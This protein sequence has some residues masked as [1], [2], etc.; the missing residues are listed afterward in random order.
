M[1][2]TGIRESFE[3]FEMLRDSACMIDHFTDYINHCQDP[4]LRQLLEGQQRIM[5]DQYQQKI[6]VIQSH[7]LDLSN[8]PRFQSTVHGQS[9]SYSSGMPGMHG[10]SIG[11]MY[12]GTSFQYGMQQQGSMMQPNQHSQNMQ[13]QYQHKAYRG[14]S[15]Q[16]ISQGALLFHKCGASMATK[17]ALECAEPHLRELAAK[18]ARTCMDMAYEI[19]KYMEQKGYYQLPNIPSNYVSHMHGVQAQVNQ[20]MYHQGFSGGQN[21]QGH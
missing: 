21:T 2:K 20:G 13:Q 12:E 1:N 18:S 14:L 15:D 19:Y 3:M 8:M 11:G 6:S 10:S 17:V 7:G 4:Q 16:A 9:Q 5:V